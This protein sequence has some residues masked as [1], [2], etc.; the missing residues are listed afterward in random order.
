MTS[1]G[2]IWNDALARAPV[3][4]ETELGVAEVVRRLGDAVDRDWAF[5]GR[6]AVVGKVS[7]DGFR[8]RMRISYRNSFQTFMFGTVKAG[9]R[10]SRIVAR[11]GMHPAAAMFML[12][13]LSIVAVGAATFVASLMQSPGDF[14]AGDGVIASLMPIAMLVF[15]VGLVGIG[16]WIAR[17]ERDSLIAFIE[18]T[19]EAEVC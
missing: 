5:F 7:A 18:E 8:L 9:G 6:K 17:G 12:L 15:G 13:W 11:T 2:A 14:G 16:R 3:T 4:F 10:G 19:A 1:L